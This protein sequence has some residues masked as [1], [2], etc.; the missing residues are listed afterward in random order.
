MGRYY[1]LKGGEDPRVAEAIGLHYQ[2]LGPG[3]AVPSEPVAV[4]VALADKLDH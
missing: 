4:A 1:A 2:P 3:D